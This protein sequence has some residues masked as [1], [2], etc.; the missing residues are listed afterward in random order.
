MAIFKE[1]QKTLI[2]RYGKKAD[3]IEKHK[4]VIESIGYCWFGK[5]GVVPGRKAIT[6]VQAEDNPMIILYS[7][8]KGYIA[9][10]KKLHINVLQKDIPNIMRKNYLKNRYFLNVILKSRRLKKLKQQTWLNLE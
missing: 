7:Q 5:I 2:I 9:F 10:L 6:S 1:G 4:E 3:C 8:G